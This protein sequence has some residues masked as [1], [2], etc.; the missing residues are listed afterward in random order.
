M[1]LERRLARQ[2]GPRLKV[3][4]F[5][6][7]E[8]MPRSERPAELLLLTSDHLG[9]GVLLLSQLGIRLTH[10]VDGGV[11]ELRHDEI[12]GTE[13]EGVAHGAAD[14]ASQDVAT[15]FVRRH[16]LVA[17]EEGDCSPVIG[18]DPK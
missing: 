10:H 15:A 13:Q 7:E 5:F 2:H 17:D 6:V 18:H 16:N 11:H 3:A 4:E 12:L 9:D 1:E 8:L 14:K